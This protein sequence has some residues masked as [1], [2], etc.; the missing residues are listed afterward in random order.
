MAIRPIA[1]RYN[2]RDYCHGLIQ[3]AHH[4]HVG[5]RSLSFTLPMSQ[6]QPFNYSR[7]LDVNGWQL[8]A[9]SLIAAVQQ[10]RHYL[11]AFHHSGCQSVP[12]RRQRHPCPRFPILTSTQPIAAS[13]WLRRMGEAR[14]LGM[15]I[16]KEPAAIGG[17]HGPA[18]ESRA[19]RR[20]IHNQAIIAMRS[21]FAGAGDVALVADHR[22]VGEAGDVI[23]EEP[24][25]SRC[26]VRISLCDISPDFGP[27]LLGLRCPDDPHAYY[28]DRLRR[29]A[30]SA[31]TSSL[32]RPRPARTEDRAASTLSCRK[33]S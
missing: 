31:S 12:H 32:G 8:S 18:P 13:G 17:R 14:A 5:K 10:T 20:P 33:A 22:K 24:I 7:M 28:V 25:Q 26:G 4:S 15:H 11:P 1:S 21:Q 3:L 23:A 29:A 19:C 30:K 2:N 27:V 6:G 9:F 16:K